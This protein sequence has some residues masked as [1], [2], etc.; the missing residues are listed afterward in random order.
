MFSIK[1]Y[2]KGL[3]NKQY[4]LYQM[5]RICFNACKNV[6]YQMIKKKTS[7][8]TIHEIDELLMTTTMLQS[9]EI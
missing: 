4:A 5:Q 9:V 3:N 6:E 7:I 1:A 2:F 8:I